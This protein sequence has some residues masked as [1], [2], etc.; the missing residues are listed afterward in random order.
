MNV[1]CA[2]IYGNY[3]INS[4]SLVCRTDHLTEYCGA[5]DPGEAD[6]LFPNATIECVAIGPILNI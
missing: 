4:G 6:S 3:E 5:I 1:W 2:H